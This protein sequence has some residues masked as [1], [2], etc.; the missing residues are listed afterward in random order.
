MSKSELDLVVL[1]YHLAAAEFVKGN[2]EP[3]KQL[4]SRREDVSIANPFAP[5]GPLSLGWRQVAQTLKL[6]AS[7][8][9]EGEVT[10]FE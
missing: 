9:R 4:F 10:S 6:G 7:H 1:T 8:W 3:Y 5:L 2:P